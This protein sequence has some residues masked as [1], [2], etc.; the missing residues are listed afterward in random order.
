MTHDVFDKLNKEI[1]Y[2]SEPAKGTL[3]FK[4]VLAKNLLSHTKMYFDD[5]KITSESEINDVLSGTHKITLLF[6]IGDY[7]DKITQWIDAFFSNEKKII[8]VN[9]N[10]NFVEIRCNIPQ[11]KLYIEKDYIGYA[12][13][14]VPFIN[15]SSVKI[16]ASQDGRIKKEK[17]IDPRNRKLVVF[18]YTTPEVE[19][20]INDANDLLDEF[21]F[22]SNQNFN[23]LTEAEDK[24]QNAIQLDNNNSEAYLVLIEILVQ[25]AE[26]EINSNHKKIANSLIE[27]I[28]SKKDK[29]LKYIDNPTKRLLI[30]KDLGKTFF[31][32]A[33]KFYTKSQKIE[34]IKNKAIVN[35]KLARKERKKIKHTANL[36]SRV[37]K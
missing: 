19:K 31:N 5:Q 25:K 17:I 30:F 24:A 13:L 12:P 22:V 18:K 14:V 6:S 8:D 7:S 35:L 3:R 34:Y 36:S 29:A 16:Q 27:K 26:K 37:L 4:P 11:T 10:I 20:Y 33:E 32:Y 15:K 9:L 21:K 2:N 23:L 28:E 1:S